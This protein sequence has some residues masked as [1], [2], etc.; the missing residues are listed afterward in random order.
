MI[1]INH[2][3]NY[4]ELTKP[5]IVS[6]VLVTAFAGIWLGTQ[7]EP[8]IGLACCTLVGVALAAASSSVLNNF[9]DRNADRLMERTQKR[10]LPSGRIKPAHALAFGLALGVL[11]FC[12]LSVWVNLV[13]AYIALGTICF[14]VLV[15]T[16]WLKPTTPHC[17]VLGGIAGALPPVMGLAAVGEFGWTALVLFSVIFLWQPPHFWA[18]A[19]VRCEEYR[20]AGFPILPVTSGVR[21]TKKQI[22]LYTLALIPVSL[23]PYWL[24]ITGQFYLIT[25]ILIGVG[26]LGWTLDFVIREFSKRRARRL[27]FFSIFY[28]TV[29]FTMFFVDYVKG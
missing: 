23:L 6:L 16:R 11:S 9:I 28:L 12:I 22:L 13:T 3:R 24:E 17:T 4:L 14:Y 5:R 20:K 1:T 27:F 8:S 2:L 15:Y 18:L 25:A 10:A 26:Y 29:L 7:G 21:A 19:L